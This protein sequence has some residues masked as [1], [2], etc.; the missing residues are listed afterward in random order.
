MIVPGGSDS[1]EETVVAHLLLGHGW[2]QFE[3][4]QVQAGEVRKVEAGVIWCHGKEREEY[5]PLL[6]ET[7]EA[8]R[9]LA[10]GKTDGDSILHGRRKGRRSPLG[11][12]GIRN[13]VRRL[14]QRAQIEGFTG[15]D[16]RRTFGSLVADASGDTLLAEKL[17]RHVL[18]GVAD[19]Y[20]VRDLPPLLEKWSPVRLVQGGFDSPLSPP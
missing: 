18:P 5:T 17:L 6:P 15:H 13:M 3:T 11:S 19:R 2:R 10:A 4:T 16:L 12:E 8:M 9:P 14:Y 20:I 7:L 1:R